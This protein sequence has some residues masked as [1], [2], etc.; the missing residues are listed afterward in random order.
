MKR[1]VALALALSL[2]TLPCVQAGEAA[3]AVRLLKNAQQGI[4]YALPK[5]SPF[6][7]TKRTIDGVYFEG[8]AQISGKYVYGH[9]SPAEEVGVPNAPPDLY[10]VPDE[11]SRA[12]LPYWN[13][14]GP[15]TGFYF[16]NAPVFLA[17]VIAPDIVSQVK[18]KK[19]KSV[20]GNLTILIDSYFATVECDAPIYTTKFIGIAVK[21]ELTAQNRYA[22]TISC[23]G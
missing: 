13:E 10:F 6:K 2:V 21:P 14:R 4:V 3:P 16:S 15:V 9:N 20:T 12:L 11:A 23:G 19:I 1:V 22:D 7:L 17:K 5:Q 8:S 18:L